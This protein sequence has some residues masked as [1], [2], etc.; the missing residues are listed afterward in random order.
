MALITFSCVA[1][2]N[3]SKVDKKDNNV[4]SEKSENTYRRSD[5]SSN[6][7]FEGSNNVLDLVDKNSAYFNDPHEVVIIKGNNNIIKFYNLN[8][9]DLSQANADTLI[10]IGDMVKYVMDS[11]NSLIFK[12]NEF[13]VDTILL[14]EKPVDESLLVYAAG[15]IDEL[16]QKHLNKLL[17]RVKNGEDEAYYELGEIFN[18]GQDVPVSTKKAIE[19]Y[20]FGAVRND[21]KSIRRLGD[22]YHNGTFE[23]Q[24][25]KEMGLFYYK[26]G[27]QLGDSY[28]EE[29]LK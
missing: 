10:I 24:P 14:K 20:E 22:I 15:E 4:V 6:I 7:I 5:K 12:K 19:F 8:V 29:M 1:T 3:A 17:A 18:F 2:Q 9:V 23:I 27:A 16:T 11:R 26:L 25:K 13:N 28:C 21:I